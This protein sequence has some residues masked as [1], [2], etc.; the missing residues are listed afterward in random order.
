ML[1]ISLTLALVS[2]F[3]W[4]KSTR[5]RLFSVLI[6]ILI[7]GS[8]FLS[9]LYYFS[10]SVTGSGIDESISWHLAANMDGAGWEDF[11]GL[12]IAALIY[13]V[14]IS[15]ISFITYKFFRPRSQVVKK[16]YRIGAA[17]ITLLM[18]YALNPAVTDLYSLYQSS[19]KRIASK[20]EPEFFVK[21]A[22]V[23]FAGKPR[24][25]VW[26]YLEQVERTYLDERL[27][28]G[29]MPNLGSLEEESLSFTNVHQVYGAGW[30]IAGM[31]ASQCG[32]P[33]VTP[34]GNESGMTGMDQFLPGAECLGDILNEA[35]YDLN[36]M[37]GAIL[38]FAGK[39]QFYQTHGFNRVEGYR[40]FVGT[41]D[42]RSYKHGWGLYDDSLYTLAKQRFDELAAKDKPF[43]LFLLTLDTH[44]PYG[45]IAK[46]CKDLVYQDGTN[47]ILNAV[48]C[49]DRLAGDFI[50]YVKDSKFFENTLFVVSSDH[51]AMRTTASK[52]IET[53]ERR[54]LWM[55]FDKEISPGKITRKGSTLDV[56][57][58][59][60]N[61]MGANLQGFG[62][63]RDMM[64]DAPTLSESEE[65][66]DEMLTR[67]R[68]Y[69][70]SLWD[71]P[72]ISDGFL[73]DPGKKQ[74][75]FGD[76]HIKLPALFVLD[77]TL[78]VKEIR[79]PFYAASLRRQV[80][81]LD[82]DQRILWVD[83]CSQNAW[84]API[85]QFNPDS[86]CVVYGTLGNEKLNR[87]AL[88]DNNTSIRISAPG[89]LFRSAPAS[90]A[91]HEKN[92]SM[93]D[94][95]I[96]LDPSF[97]ESE[98]IP[99]STLDGIIRSFMSD[100]IRDKPKDVSHGHV[101][102]KSAGFKVRRSY[103]NNAGRSYII[104]L[105]SGKKIELERGLTIV[106][107]SV[108]DNPVK[109]GHL[110]TCLGKVKDDVRL[111]KYFQ[112]VLETHA[113]E[114]D[115]FAIIMHDSAVCGNFNLEPLFAGTGLK[116][117]DKIEYRQ[118]YIA[119][120]SGDGSIQERRGE[121]ESWL[122][123]DLSYVA[124]KKGD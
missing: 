3:L 100:G 36:Y 23:K 121:K 72:Q 41:L 109:L 59:V 99:E 114:F 55:I 82:Y 21:I 98:R 25:I 8:L 45:T 120:I 97:E 12:I 63:G 7:F 104:D 94:E 123:E 11:S 79:F 5:S 6:S 42:D 49:A 89:K 67:S 10:D 15:V 113:D 50:H 91:F 30:T 47:P 88:H 46:S 54:N 22:P 69:L 37:G 61:L 83:K 75:A 64:K 52:L 14:A 102:L 33:L 124:R 107:F 106:G 62:F 26:L 78:G 73:V 122:L 9:G 53:G 20:E 1:A 66:V 17:F 4:R 16:K 84:L 27:F 57:P 92:L 34:S 108:K 35:G 28:P 40:K 77:K 110:D 96:L 117:W 60:L 118:P 103:I 76:R 58:T 90:P 111:D 38:S 70:S 44:H 116:Q 71:Y 39:G 29:L 86:F 19:L 87:I 65:P 48:H 56:A 13:L 81:K 31:V 24:N 101:V 80:G 2:I 51:L 115:G 18:S 105:V 95:M 119:I 74:L 112:T 85:S 43:G 32:I 93:L 68:G